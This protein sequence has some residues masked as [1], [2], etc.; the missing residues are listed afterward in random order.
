MEFL[1]TVSPSE[2]D[3]RAAELAELD[4]PED[5]FRI[6]YH[7]KSGNYMRTIWEWD[8]MLTGSGS[9]RAL[10]TVDRLGMERRTD[11]GLSCRALRLHQEFTAAE[12]KRMRQSLH[13]AMDVLTGSVPADTPAAAVLAAWQSLFFI[14]PV[15]STTFSSF[16]R[17]FSQL[18]RESLGWL[19][20]RYRHFDTLSG[21]LTSGLDR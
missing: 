2:H 11:Q 1:G 3:T 13:A 6:C 8:Q 19:W 21:Y 20:S 14:V 5:A 16:P 12:P 10:R 18:G 7:R 17:V 15:I 4:K 9:A